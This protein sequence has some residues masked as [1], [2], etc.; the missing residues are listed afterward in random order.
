MSLQ[1]THDNEKPG[2]PSAI[3]EILAA[4]QNEINKKFYKHPNLNLSLQKLENQKIFFLKF[5]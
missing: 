2:R 1:Q 5:P 3:D 4:L